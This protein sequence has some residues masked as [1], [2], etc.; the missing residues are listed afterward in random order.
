MAIPQAPDLNPIELLRGARPSLAVG[1]V[2]RRN[3]VPNT[4][5]IV[6][7][8][9]DGVLFW[10]VYVWFNCAFTMSKL[11]IFIFIL[12]P[13]TYEREWFNADRFYSI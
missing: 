10:Y 4:I 13:R 12:V 5:E 1:L 3:C 8:Y 7:Q 2:F 11:E 6:C 9:L